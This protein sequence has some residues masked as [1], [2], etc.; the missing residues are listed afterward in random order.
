MGIL[1]LCSVSAI[2]GFGICAA[3]TNGKICDLE[4]EIF[5]LS[6]ENKRL[7]KRKDCPEWSTEE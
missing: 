6:R 7:E 2:L 3:L 4:S 5:R 1:A